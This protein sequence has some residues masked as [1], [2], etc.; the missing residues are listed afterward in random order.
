MKARLTLSLVALCGPVFAQGNFEVQ[1][2]IGSMYGGSVDVNSDSPNTPG[3][4]KIALN[5][6]ISYGITAGMNFG[7]L[8]GAEFLWN[9]QR[10][11]AVGKL[12]GGGEFSEKFDVSNNQYHG[13]FLFYFKPLDSKW[14]P[15]AL[16]GLGATNISGS[17]DVSGTSDSITKFS[18]GL[19]GGI[20]YYFT[21]RIGIR[22]QARYA[23]TYLYTSNGGLWCNWWGYCWV[24]GN[25]HYL[26]QGDIT[27]GMTIRF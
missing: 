21:D 19:G 1:P 22:A 11:K 14:R 8:F 13:N 17:S 4:N 10:T 20:K 25:D 5:S 16:V 18:Y 7:D 24:V 15:Y 26:N 6:S 9:Q 2:F 12:Q 23:P 27:I 3:I